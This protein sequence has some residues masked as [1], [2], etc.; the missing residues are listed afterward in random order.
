MA[1]ISLQLLFVGRAHQ[2]KASHLADR[3]NLQ[4]FPQLIDIYNV[5]A[6]QLNDEYAA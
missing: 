4:S 1:L 5:F 2:T 3:V 6:R